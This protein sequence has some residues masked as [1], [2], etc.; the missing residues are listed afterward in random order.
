MIS[1]QTLAST[2]IARRWLAGVR[3]LGF[4]IDA[5]N[6]VAGGRRTACI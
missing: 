3:G 5:I 4:L 6:C 1:I 2:L